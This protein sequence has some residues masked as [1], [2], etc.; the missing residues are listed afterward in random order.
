LVLVAGLENALR[1][2]FSEPRSRELPEEERREAEALAATSRDL[3]D[4][5]SS[6]AWIARLRALVPA[7]AA[8]AREAGEA[9]AG[10]PDS[11]IAGYGED[12]FDNIVEDKKMLIQLCDEVRE[13][14]ETAQF[15]LVDLERDASNPETVNKIFRSF[16]TIKSSGAFLGLKNVEETA[17]AMEDLLVRVR[18]GKIAVTS[19]LADVIF[20]G[21]GMLRDFVLVI[22]SSDYEAKRM[23][24][25]FRRVDIYPYIGIIRKIISDRS[26]KKIGEILLEYGKLDK[27]A[28]A[29][30]LSKQAST[31]QRFGEI[32]VGENLVSEADF[33]AA[34]QRQTAGARKASYV[35]VSNERLNALI[36]IV[37]E[38]VVNQ[39]MIRQ[40]MLD[41]E[42]SRESSERTVSQLETI[43]TGIKNLVLSMGMV[44]I[45][46][47]FNKLRV[48]VRNT[49]ADTGK[50]VTV[51]F[52]GEDTELDRNVIEG[53]YDPLV[54]IVRNAVDHGIEPPELREAA[55]KPR[56]S[57]I[58]ISAAHKGNGIEISVAD[59][60]KGIDR[61]RVIAKA[62]ERGVVS[63]DQA[64]SLSEKDAYSF[65]F[66]PGFSTAEKVTEVSGRGVGL[67]VVRKNV[68]QIRG[69]VDVDSE[70]GKGTAF[71]IRIPLTL[72]IID[73]F[74]TVVDGTKY[75]FPFNLIS[76]I[77]VPEASAVSA[78]EDGHLML[79]NRGSYIPVIFSSEV[80]DRRPREGVRAGK[81]QD[82]A[83]KLVIVLGFEGRNYGVAVDSIIGKQ[84]I[85]IK[86]LNEAL[87][88]MKVFSGGTIFGDGSIGFVVD[89]EEFVLFARN[90]R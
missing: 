9:A 39:S 18:D 6:E 90:G 25:S 40:Y 8:L 60:G 28:V 31:N 78:L 43:T 21:I 22:E 89:V 11:A 24:D 82:V 67:D 3:L 58:L 42:I 54:H 32:A 81:A 52:S 84:E 4:P 87:Y 27:G 50:T 61:S 17:H 26:V 66:L 35:K 79:L 55:G 88:R 29:E 30:I 74:V 69:K 65:I 45:A 10:V 38:L 14:L 19:E 1:A 7:L 51:D 5:A 49:A 13:H 83:D 20:Y 63:E 76:E 37:G 62:V 80:F 68:E 57:R 59:D 53:I 75:I 72:A 15:T 85:V 16:H 77:V 23:V 70:P 46:E 34:L 56:M 71:T 64:A 73:G 36:D 47:V 12:Y 48:V 33:R 2:F 44:P 86:S 41:P